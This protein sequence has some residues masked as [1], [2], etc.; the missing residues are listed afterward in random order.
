MEAC[1]DHLTRWAGTFDSF[2]AFE[3]TLSDGAR[4]PVGRVVSVADTL[5]SDWAEDRGAYV[6]VPS[7]DETVVVNR[8]P[9]RI[10]G[11]DCGPRGGIAHLGAHNR[12]VLADVL[13]LDGAAIA[14][15]EADGALVADGRIAP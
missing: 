14:E 5:D 3:S 11:T 15:L 6:E 1:V 8:A 4:L 9:V 10:S 12:A 7:A 2:E 13:G